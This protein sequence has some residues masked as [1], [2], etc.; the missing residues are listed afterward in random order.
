MECHN[1]TLPQLP[2]MHPQ[3]Q[4]KKV[5]D[6]L[7]LSPAR[8][9]EEHSFPGLTLDKLMATEN[10]AHS[11]F[12]RRKS[13]EPGSGDS[14]QPTAGPLSTLE[15]GAGSKWDRSLLSCHMSSPPFVSTPTDTDGPHA[16]RAGER[17][18]STGSG[19]VSCETAEWLF[20]I[21]LQGQ[22]GLYCSKE[23]ICLCEWVLP[24]SAGSCLCGRPR[25]S[26]Q[27]LT[28][29]CAVEIWIPL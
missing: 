14:K 9:L 29:E 5:I 23:W 17:T 25:T 7:L 24:L 18:P 10:A 16:L 21:R 4:K 3:L 22:P 13:D 20:W 11:F 1:P 6:A 12:L 8:W 27:A 2:Q 15:P 28:A 19:T 26:L